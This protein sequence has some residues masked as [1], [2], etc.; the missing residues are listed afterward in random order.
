MLLSVSNLTKAYGPDEILTG[1]TFRVAARE[2]VALVGRNGTGKTTLL[3]IITGRLEGDTGAV[4]RAQGAKVGY[5]RQEAPVTVGLTV[6]EEAEQAVAHRLELKQRLEELE[7]RLHLSG[8]EDPQTPNAEGHT[9]PDYGAD[10]EEYAL[11]H[12]HFLEAEGYSAE[13][14]IRVVLQKMGFTEDEFD[15][16]TSSLS[17]GEKTRLAIARL[18]L[19]EPDLLILD[20]PTN[21]LD[22][23][24]TEWL[25]GWLRG[26]HGAVLLVSHDRRFLEN[27]ADRV[28]E[29]RE[30]KVFAYPGPFEKFL[31]LKAEEDARLTE[32]ARRQDQEIAKMDEYV[33][34]FMNSQRT[35]QARGRQKL[36]N[37]LI[38]SKVD[39]PKA[40]R[41]MK[42]GFGEAGRSGDIV[43]EAEKLLIGYGPPLFPELNWTVRIGERWGVVGENGSGKS[44][45][46]R[47]LLGQQ[48][49]LNGRVRLGSGVVAGYFSQDAD[50]LD[51]NLSPLD[52]L[53]YDCDL[54]PAEARNLLGRFL[55]TGDDVYRPVR[56]LSGGEKNKLSLARLTTLHPNLLV[57]DEPTNHLDMAS[58]EALAQVLKQ[59]TGTMILVSHDRWLLENV[60]THTLD[61][62]RSGAVAYPGSYGEYRA[63]QQSGGPLPTPKK[64]RM[65]V[66]V[67]PTPYLSPRE[68]SKE[69]ERTRKLIEQLE[70]EIASTEAALK[71]LEQRL[72]RPPAGSDVLSMTKDHQQL[73]ETLQGKMAAWE[74][75]S[76]RLEGLQGMQGIKT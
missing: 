41:N 69:I 57:L 46:V 8:N 39:A 49:A 36:M 71:H 76:R 17:G 61:I 24:A 58:R 54:L 20:E 51:P 23:Q 2:K 40:D 63:W 72:S 31:R 38:A 66:G 73:T 27:T 5:L 42:A 62:R 59:F 33:R 68:V 64:T 47:T 10:L 74:E 28:L 15:K 75:Q 50:D 35:A 26:Y 44:T 9:P 1:V 7:A 3:K 19:E 67:P 14:D 16:P 29:M 30:G 43:A 65:H 53:V 70:Q 21:H 11:L 32:V 45:L 48:E 6:L 37:R 25:E 18:L 12:E 34:R 55:I 60:T 13:R 4:Q 22:L 52:S 56:T